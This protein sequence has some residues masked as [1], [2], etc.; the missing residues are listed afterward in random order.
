[1]I[2]KRSY[3]SLRTQNGPITYLSNISDTNVI[4]SNTVPFPLL[5][6]K[7]PQRLERYWKLNCILI[8]ETEINLNIPL[9]LVCVG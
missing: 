9:L 1:M 2:I 6:F 5:E 7:L 3:S 8:E 4:L